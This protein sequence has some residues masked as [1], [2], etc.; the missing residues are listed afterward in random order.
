MFQIESCICVVFN[1]LSPNSAQNQFS[2]KDIIDYHEQ[3]L[4]EL[5]KWSQIEK[6]LICYQI[7]STNSL[8]K[9][10]EIS[11]ENLYVDIGT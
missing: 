9:C 2:P 7:L 10:M 6:Y 5:T 11:L 3:R 8:R 1:P 4:W